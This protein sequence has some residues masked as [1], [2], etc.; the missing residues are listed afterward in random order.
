M[1]KKR[2]RWQD[3][4][5]SNA[6]CGEFTQAGECVVKDANGNVLRT[7]PPMRRD[8]IETRVAKRSSETGGR[9]RRLLVARFATRCN[10]CGKTINEGDAFGW[11]AVLREGFCAGCAQRNPNLITARG[12]VPQP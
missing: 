10:D 4:K 1:V 11:N 7:E 6:R 3:T 8:Q 12:R 5:I 9:R 2:Y